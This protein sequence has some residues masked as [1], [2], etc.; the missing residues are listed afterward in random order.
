MSASATHALT[1]AELQEIRDIAATA[2]GPSAERT[3]HDVTELLA[4]IRDACERAARSVTASAVVEAA[5]SDVLASAM[6]CVAEVRE[7]QPLVARR[8][9]DALAD[10]LRAMRTRNSR[11]KPGRGNRKAPRP[12]LLRMDP[13]STS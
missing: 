1:D 9:E 5:Y 6:Q 10:L 8:I 13:R 11:L 12:S 7:S 3:E 2:D 4:A